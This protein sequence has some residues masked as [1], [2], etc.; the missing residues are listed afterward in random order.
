GYKIA[1]PTVLARL[2]AE[3]LAHLFIGYGYRPYFVEGDQPEQ[4]HQLLAATLDR[5]HSEIQMI[6]LQARTQGFSKRPIWPMIILRTPKGWTG[7]KTV[8]GIP[9]EGTF[10]SHQVPLSELAAKPGH[11]QILEDWM[12]GYHP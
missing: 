10:R 1:G 12:K 8:D 6:Q 2:P 9:V 7:P 3:E 11:I 4:V 5:V